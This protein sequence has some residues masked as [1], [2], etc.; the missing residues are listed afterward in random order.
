[1]KIYCISLDVDY[2]RRECLSKKF[3]TK[4][5][6]FYIVSAVNGN[7][8]TAKNY[9]GYTQSYFHKYKYLLTP[10]EIGCSLSHVAALKSFLKT[11]EKYALILEDDVIGSDVD[12]ERI[13]KIVDRLDFTGVVMCGGQEGLPLDWNDYRY[14]K[15][16]EIDPNLYKVNKYSIKFFSR[17]VCYVV[18]RDFASHYVDMNDNFIHL[19]DDWVKYFD[20]TNYSF[21]YKN[22]MKHPIDLSGSHIES[23]RK[24]TQKAQY[25]INFLQ[26]IFWYKCYRKLI[27]LG[28]LLIS[29]LS[30][31]EKIK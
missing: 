3:K 23:Q 14:G 15:S 6:E 29:I 2:S 10:S 27:N 20:N 21:Y 25:K 31:D 13:K 28:Y 22:I 1:M 16:T 12:I 18:D 7:E 9:F 24:L 11:D 5:S 17:T 4:Y 19:A 30:K 26:T 8:L